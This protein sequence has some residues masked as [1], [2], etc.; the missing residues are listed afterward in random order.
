MK[1]IGDEYNLNCIFMSVT[2]I[3]SLFIYMHLD[4]N[5]WKVLKMLQVFHSY[6]E[7]IEVMN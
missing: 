2:F 4:Y 7:F 3:E 1:F 6:D 5:S